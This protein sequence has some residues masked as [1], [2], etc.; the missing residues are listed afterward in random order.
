MIAGLAGYGLIRGSLISGINWS[1]FEIEKVLFE[2]SENGY[3]IG[4]E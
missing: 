4:M 1:F 3:F 2:C